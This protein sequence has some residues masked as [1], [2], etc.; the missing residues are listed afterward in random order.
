LA[1]QSNKD[2]F[3]ADYQP[4][5]VIQPWLRLLASMF[6]DHA[7]IITLG[8]SYEGREILG[9][10]VGKPAAPIE[11]PG[12]PD[13]P[14]R[15]PRRA[16]KT[17]L[18]TGGMHARE[19][20]SVAA[21][22]YVAHQLVTM[23]GKPSKD[24][25]IT[26]LVDEF[27]WVFIPSLNPDG[28]E[29]TWDSDRLWRKNRQPTNLRFCSGID[30]DRGFGYRFDED[31]AGRMSPCSEAWSGGHAWEAYEARRVRE[32]VGNLTNPEFGAGDEL[33]AYLD[34]H[35]YSQQVLYPYA[36]SCDEV[37]PTLETLEEV[38]MG[39]ARAMA[40][41]GGKGYGYS[42]AAACE[43][44]VLG[45][46]ASSKKKTTKLPSLENGG[47]SPLDWFYHEI[48]VRY[49]FQIKLR[50]TGSY[51]FLLPKE[52]IV[53]QGK[54]VLAAVMHLGR[55]LLGE[56]GLAVDESLELTDEAGDIVE[57]STDAVVDESDELRELLAKESTGQA[58]EEWSDEDALLS[59]LEFRKRRR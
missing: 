1:L 41:V 55:F 57:S 6:P 23:Y 36:F 2:L 5:N 59:K 26:R 46:K 9:L 33:V 22:N 4:L 32:W 40:R 52:E 3:F 47:G 13:A 34:L 29:H 11:D 25:I 50:D 16:R 17:V 8:T 21:V 49:A 19:W 56:I 10:R 48:G 38:A 15:A 24:K 14:A 12:D 42:V 39:L 27:D 20:I 44:N 35:S 18:I 58:N 37:P 31:A 28:Y 54:E 53:P 43:G 30:L 45:K 7:R 51:G